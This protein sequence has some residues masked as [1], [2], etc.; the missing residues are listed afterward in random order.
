MSIRWVHKNLRLHYLWLSA[1][2]NS[3]VLQMM[4]FKLVNAGI[5]LTIWCRTIRQ[6]AENK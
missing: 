3:D 5:R 1:I 4:T 6:S 2:Y